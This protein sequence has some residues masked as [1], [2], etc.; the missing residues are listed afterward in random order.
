MKI[1]QNFLTKNNCYLKGQAITVKGV[2]LHSTACLGVKAIN[3]LK[4]WNVPKPNGAKVCFHAFLDDT[5]IYQT[6]PWNFQGWHA[7]GNANNS[8]IGF[9]ICEPKDYS[10][11]E[12]FI[13]T[14]NK[15]KKLCVYLCQKFN[16]KPESITTS[17]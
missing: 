10:N 1:I 9:E 2:M 12:Y 7:G 16:L 11:E 15:A 4:S 8:Y 13:N 3:F 14:K 17:L 6:L 5:G